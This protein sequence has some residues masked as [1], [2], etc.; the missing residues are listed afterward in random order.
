MRK[1]DR[2]CRAIAYMA[3]QL[4]NANAQTVTIMARDMPCVGRGDQRSRC[5]RRSRRNGRAVR[6]RSR[7]NP[8]ITSSNRG[9]MHCTA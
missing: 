8:S 9:V 7:P 4:L 6:M 1:P 5:L 3:S 2:P